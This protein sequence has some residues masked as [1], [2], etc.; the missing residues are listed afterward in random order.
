MILSRPEI[1]YPYIERPDAF[2]A[3]LMRVLN[4]GDGRVQT[5]GERAE[6]AARER[7]RDGAE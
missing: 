4:A 7:E 5:D 3:E 1:S 2:H 6:Q